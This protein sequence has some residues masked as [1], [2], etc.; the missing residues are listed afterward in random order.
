MT[1][2]LKLITLVVTF[3][4]VASAGAMAAISLQNTD[5]DTLGVLSIIDQNDIQAAQLAEQKTINHA[6]LDYARMLDLDHNEHLDETRHLS[7]QLGM[8]IEDNGSLEELRTDGD[9]DLAAL[10]VLDAKDFSELYIADMI[11][12]QAE[13]LDW[14]DMQDTQNKKVKKFLDQ[15]REI[16]DRCLET[17]ERIQKQQTGSL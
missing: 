3:L 16:L 12:G 13:A 2:L 14:I 10:T 7:Q 6:V 15:T 11:K 8:T 4:G 5:A 17:A 9:Q 1:N